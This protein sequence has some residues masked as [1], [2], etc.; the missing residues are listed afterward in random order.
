MKSKI[1]PII[2]ASLLLIPVG[3]TAQNKKSLDYIIDM[4]HHN[5]GE[6]L[7][8]SQYDRPDV[9]RKMGYNSKCFAPD[10]W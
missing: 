10:W 3:V 9:L 2:I 7:Y 6:P 5:P 1:L 4:V 8:D